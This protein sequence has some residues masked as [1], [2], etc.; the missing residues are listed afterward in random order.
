MTNPTRTPTIKKVA[1]IIRRCQLRDDLTE[2]RKDYIMT[3][4][5]QRHNIV[6]STV[7]RVAK[8]WKNSSLPDHI[9]AKVRTDYQTGL[10][11]AALINKQRAFQIGKDLRVST[12]TVNNIW[13][14]HKIEMKSGPTPIFYREFAPIYTKALTS[15]PAPANPAWYY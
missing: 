14:K 12:T 7:N 8:G 2:A 10:D 5:A 13:H 1:E 15:S 3:A 11:L 9:L 6:S 4:I